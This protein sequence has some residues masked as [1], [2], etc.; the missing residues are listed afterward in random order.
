M[1]NL[2]DRLESSLHRTEATGLYGSSGGG[3]GASI[4]TVQYTITGGAAT[5]TA[6]AGITT[7]VP[8]AA[9]SAIDNTLTLSGPNEAQGVIYVKQSSAGSRRVVIACPSRTIL[10]EVNTADD[11]PLALGNALTAY[12]FHLF[13]AVSVAYCR[14]TKVFL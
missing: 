3:G 14:L 8:I 13:T 2:A 5:L 11:L 6:G 1:P 12:S 4:A 9:L 7:F 10:R